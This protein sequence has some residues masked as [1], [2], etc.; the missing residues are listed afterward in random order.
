MTDSSRK[1][2]PDFSDHAVDPYRRAQ[3]FE[4]ADAAYRHAGP[5]TDRDLDAWE[6]ALADSLPD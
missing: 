2:M 3:L 4:A 1:P 6:N 5:S